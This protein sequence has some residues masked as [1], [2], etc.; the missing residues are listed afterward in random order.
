MS[1][2]KQFFHACA[3]GG[4]IAAAAGFSGSALA[5]P[6][7]ITA[8]TQTGT[9]TALNGSGANGTISIQL[10]GERYLTVQV[11]ATG[12]EPGIQHLAIFTAARRPGMW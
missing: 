11:D 10:R 12:L 6:S 1:R 5:A 3:A 8:Q 9:L 7:S 2:F 4:F